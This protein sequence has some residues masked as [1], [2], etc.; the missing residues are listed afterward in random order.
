[1]HELGVVF[2]ALDAVEDAIAE[3]DDVNHV[4]NVTIKLGELSGVVP[5]LLQDCWAWAVSKRDKMNEC[6]LRIEQIKALTHCDNCGCDYETIPNGK[7]C[8]E[9]GSDK[10]SLICGNEFILERIEA[11]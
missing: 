11:S 10:T 5:H 8:P 6:A 4:D 1:M 3:R 7:I 9:C 2:Y